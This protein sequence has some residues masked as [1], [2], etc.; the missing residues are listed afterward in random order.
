MTSKESILNAIRNVA[1][2]DIPRGAK[3]ILYGSQAR[4]DSHKDSDWDL[5][6]LIDKNK[7]TPSDYDLYSY[8]FWELG[9]SIDAMIHPTLY[10][11]KDWEV[12]AN[13]IFRTNVQRDGIEL[14]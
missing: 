14:C 10:T 3:V 9:W 12:K 11:L 5:L 6:I 7:L 8:P 4:G 1:H 2:S 13:P